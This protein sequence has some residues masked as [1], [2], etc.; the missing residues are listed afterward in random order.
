[1]SV[2]KAVIW[3]D[4]TEKEQTELLMRPAVLAGADIAKIV[5]AIVADVRARGDD[6][7]RDYA[8]KFDKTALT[9]IR[10]SEKEIEEAE[11]RLG[12]ELKEAMQLAVK[13]I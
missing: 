7:L 10:V 3:N 6:A 5:D 11:C 13:N 8:A 12:D 4:L 9:T 1:M 2:M